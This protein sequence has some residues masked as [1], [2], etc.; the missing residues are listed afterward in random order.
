[1]SQL[2]EAG[3]LRRLFKAFHNFYLNDVLVHRYE[4]G[5]GEDYHSFVSLWRYADENGFL[6]KLFHTAWN[7]FMLLYVSQHG[8]SCRLEE[9]RGG[10]LGLEE[11]LGRQLREGEFEVPLKYQQLLQYLVFLNDMSFETQSFKALINNKMLFFRDNNKLKNELLDQKKA[12]ENHLA[13]IRD[14]EKALLKREKTALK[15]LKK[16]QKSRNP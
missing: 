11:E 8:R 9:V 12:I 13:A 5:A 1:M 3:S 14:A 2:K 15:L 6:D 10:Y 16:E 7:K 4:E